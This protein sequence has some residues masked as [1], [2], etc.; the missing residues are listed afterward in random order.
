MMRPRWN[1]VFSDLLDNKLR[2][3]LV[4]LSIAVGVLSVGVIA[5]GYVIISEDMGISYASNNPANIEM[6]MDD[7]ENDLLTTIQNMREVEKAEGRNV[8]NVRVRTLDSN[9][10][11]TLDIFAFEN[12]EENEINLLEPVEGATFP[13]KNEIM[14]EK[15]ALD[16]LKVQIGQ[17]VEFQLP[18][19]T[20]KT[21]PVVGIVQDAGTGAGDFL[22]APIGYIHMDSLPTF[23]QPEVF[24]RIYATV[25]GD[26][27]DL[28]NIRNAAAKI[29]D[30][31]E[32]NDYA[33]LQTFYSK[34]HEHPLASTINAVLGILLAL[35]ILIVFLSSSLIANTLSALLNQHLRHIGV[36]KL[37]GGRRQQILGM[38]LILILCF[39]FLALLI[40]IP[41]GG[42]GAYSLANFIAS[43][44]KF[45]LLGYRFVPIALI[46]QIAIALLVPLVAGLVPVI[47]GSRVTVLAAISGE[48][49]E[50]D[51]NRV[52]RIETLQMRANNAL[53]RR[54]L[55]IPRPFLIS[56][57]NTF[58]RTGRLILTL[59]TLTMG[60]AIFIAVFNVRVTLHDYIDDIG[61]YFL[62]DV[63]LDFDKPYR[64]R[65]I[66]QM[67]MQIEGVTS[68][69]GWL[70]MVSEYLDSEGKI[71]DNMTIMAP[72]GDSQL[73]SPILVSGRWIQADDERKLAISEAIL[74]EIPEL[75][76]GDFL[77]MKVGGKTEIWEVVG[78]FKFIGMEGV[79]GY[80]PYE[81]VSQELNLANRSYTYRVVTDQHDRASQTMMAETIDQFFRDQGFKVRQAQPGLAMMDAA[82]ESLDILVTFLLIMALLTATVG[83]MGLMGTMGMNVLERTRE[84]G[85]MRSIGAG[86]RIVMLTVVVEGMVIGLISWILGAIVAF[87]I[88][89][90]LSNIL[91]VTIFQTPID[92]VFTPT[93]F[94]IWLILVLILSALASVLPARNA[95][96]LTIHEVLAYE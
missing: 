70:F 3:V 82:S 40:A 28:E 48:Q 43:E 6:R 71:I 37:V 66:E 83:S 61:K 89:V 36:M 81:Y 73:V 26:Q 86:D 54:G 96:R 13:Q 47:N 56:M 52:S 95:A 64:L 44:M 87:P 27:D 67:A 50:G 65:E 68:T 85:I 94:V 10:W 76:P 34:T 7:F 22:A 72:P 74:A 69:E 41:V 18:D 8:F 24:N 90:L 63:N 21:M 39:S 5:G 9:Q 55:H 17:Q 92:L 30:K 33:V 91:S 19:G 25:N 35:G 60:G 62:A 29:K 77:P 32:K 88:S 51:P 12:F 59:F 93:G 15:K 20:T 2:T 75:Q 84:I 80:A 53:I 31:V 57:R 11:V 49:S 46:S 79:F 45:N 14:L 4:V 42:Q 38:Y 58:R 23:Q 16:D 1:K 78:I